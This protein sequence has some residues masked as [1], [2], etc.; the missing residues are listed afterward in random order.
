MVSVVVKHHVYLQVTISLLKLSTSL[1]W[2]ISL[3]RLGGSDRVDNLA[4]GV[5]YLPNKI[6]WLRSNTRLQN[7]LVVEADCIPDEAE[8]PFHKAECLPHHHD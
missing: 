5:E 3:A 6:P 1:K 8:Y 4:D 7:L 2:I